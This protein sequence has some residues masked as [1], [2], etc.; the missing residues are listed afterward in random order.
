MKSSIL[1]SVWSINEKQEKA[2][3][4]EEIGAMKVKE[5]S[6]KLIVFYYFTYKNLFIHSSFNLVCR[7]GACISS[8]GAK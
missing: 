4:M 2:V 3:C 1:R 7:E 5:A 8:T 6:N